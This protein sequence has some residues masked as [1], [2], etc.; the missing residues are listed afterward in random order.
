MEVSCF[1]FQSPSPFALEDTSG[2]STTCTFDRLGTVSTCISCCFCSWFWW[3]CISDRRLPMF[4]I[5][6]Y[7]RSVSVSKFL[8][9]YLL[10]GRLKVQHVSS[11]VLYS[12]RGSYWT[13]SCIIV[14]HHLANN[15]L[16]NQFVQQQAG[17]HKNS[18]PMAFSSIWVFIGSI[19][20]TLMLLSSLCFLVRGCACV[21][22]LDAAFRLCTR[23]L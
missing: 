1:I 12:S 14:T 17:M 20:S 5:S 15:M 10:Q 4:C 21:C 3:L 23:S 11:S 22:F 6:A 9:M 18:G 8:A 13:L 16:R 2:G 19:L 7:H